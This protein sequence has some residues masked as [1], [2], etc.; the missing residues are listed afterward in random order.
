ML[1]NIFKKG[2]YKMKKYLL[3]GL[4]IAG[5]MMAA[6]SAQAIDFSKPYVLGEAGYSFGIKNAG[7]AGILGIGAGYHVNEFLRADLTVG[8]RGWSDVNMKT[9]VGKRKTDMWS[10]PVLANL[11]G[12][13]PLN[14]RLS[15]YGMGGLGMAW[16][17]T[18]DMPDAKG[19]SKS[20]FAWTAG[21]GLDYMVNSCLSFDLGYRYTDLGEA[22]V[23]SR[24]GYTGKTKQDVR[25]NDVKLTARYYF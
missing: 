11:Y 18:D 19:A 9:A 24:D 5:L 16:N 1:R 21:V 7:D 14:N 6:T 15:I 2:E 13:V 3:S 12:T 8:Y 17:V 10:L 20:N 4:A 22:R 23:K 25:S